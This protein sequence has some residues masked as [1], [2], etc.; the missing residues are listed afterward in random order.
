MATNQIF[1]QRIGYYWTCVMLA[2]ALS[3]D[4]LA[5]E[6]EMHSEEERASLR[7]LASTD[8]L[9]F[10]NVL[11]MIA[12]GLYWADVAATPA[13]LCHAYRVVLTEEHLRYALP[14]D[15]RMKGTPPGRIRAILKER[16]EALQP[17]RQREPQEVAARPEPSS[18]DVMLRVVG[19][20]TISMDELHE[21][22][23]ANGLE[24]RHLNTV[25]V[26]QTL[27]SAVIDALM[28]QLYAGCSHARALLLKARITLIA[29]LQ[30]WQRQ[31]RQMVVKATPMWSEQRQQPV[32]RILVGLPEL[33]PLAA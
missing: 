13:D 18:E 16:G 6:P 21:A 14:W 33:A 9:S 19:W 27:L 25:A 5:P 32:C 2:E 10:C 17:A 23:E 4:P 15:C 11:R 12:P 7:T 31:S 20:Q 8:G 28:R 22:I 3:D 26:Q 29:A 30:R 1:P 24:S